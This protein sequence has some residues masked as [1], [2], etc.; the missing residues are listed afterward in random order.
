MT[1][2]FKRI[3]IIDDDIDDQ[4]IILSAIKLIG[5]AYECEFASNGT[6]AIEYAEQS[7]PYDI[8][9]IDLNMPLMNGFDTLRILRSI[10]L[11]DDVPLVIISTSNNNYDMDRAKQLGANRYIIKPDTFPG[12]VN[13]LKL[14]LEL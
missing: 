12:L 4:M 11:Y 6:E 3:L 5:P 2:K 10:K 14:A 9:L 13:E 7:M 8:V 1:D